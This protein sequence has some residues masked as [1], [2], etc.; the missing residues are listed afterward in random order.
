MKK[1]MT[2][3]GHLLSIHEVIEL[4]LVFFRRLFDSAYHFRSFPSARPE[5]IHVLSGPGWLIFRSF[6]FWALFSLV[7]REWSCLRMLLISC[8]R[9]PVLTKTRHR[10]SRASVSAGA[11]IWS[12][13]VRVPLVL[14]KVGSPPWKVLITAIPSSCKVSLN[15]EAAG[16]SSPE[17]CLLSR[18]CSRRRS[19]AHPS[20]R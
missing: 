11:A 6:L 18:P 9:I 2:A 17:E 7:T 5:R 1:S 20:S 15:K 4:R 16:P 13:R 10:L 3:F 12:I 8:T 19:W 14:A